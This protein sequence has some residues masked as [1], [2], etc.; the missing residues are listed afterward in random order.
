MDG[1]GPAAP[2]LCHSEMVALGGKLG[3][4]PFR[5]KVHVPIGAEWLA[6]KADTFAEEFARAFGKSLGKWAG[7][8]MS[9]GGLVV[10]LSHVIQ[11]AANWLQLV[12]PGF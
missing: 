4:V 5:Q 6:G 7:V 11:S 3:H 10:A 9:V 12:L 2:V 1:Y 8:A